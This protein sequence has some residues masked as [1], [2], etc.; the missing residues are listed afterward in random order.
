MANPAVEVQALGQ[1]IWQDF[2]RRG[3]IT[4]GELEELVD[5]EGLLGITSNPSIF[6]KA[7]AGS[8]DYDDDLRALASRGSAGPGEIYE[9]LALDDIRAAARVLEPAYRRTDGRDGFVSFE[10]SPH[11]AHDTEGTVRE[12]RRLAAAV[13]RPNVMIKV[14]GTPE[15]VPAIEQLTAEGVK[16]NVTLLFG[17]DAYEAAANAFVAGLERRA[18]TG[19]DLA[20]VASVASFF[21]SRIDTAVDERL[22]ALAERAGS[23]AA[24]A[25]LEALRGR[26]AIAD[27][28]VAWERY[29]E[30]VA[31][32]RWR[33]LAA[34]GARPQRLL[35]ASTSTKNPRYPKLMYV[36]ALIGED[37]VDT[38]PTG[39]FRE[40]QAHGRVRATLAE[41]LEHAQETLHALAAA[42][43][44]MDEVTRALLEDGVSKFERSFD[45][46]IA[47]IERKRERLLGARMDDQRL[48]LGPGAEAQQEAVDAWRDGGKVRRLWRGDAGLWTDRGEDRWLGWLHCV[49]GAA[50]HLEPYR[51]LAE[52]ARAAGLGHVLLLGMGGSSLFPWV[53]AR[54]VGGR[55]GAP[56]LSVLDSTLPG[57]IRAAERRCE[58]GRTL[59]VVSSK[60]GS[61]VEPLTLERHFRERLRSEGIARPGE[62]FVA[63]T[64]PGSPLETHAARHRY[65][66]VLAGD[67]AIGG[68]Y[69]ALSAFGLVPAALLGVAEALLDRAEIMVQA[70]ASCVPPD[71]NP[72]VSLGL[73]LGTLAARGV[74]KVTLA[75]SPSLA[76]FGAWVE[77]LL[78]EST[79]KLGRG[80]VP[81]VGE[82]L[83]RPEAYGKDR[84]FVHLRDRSSPP[85]D[86]EGRIATLERAGHPVVRIAVESPVELAQ[87]VFRWEMATA[88]AGA[89]LHLDPFD[90]PDVESSK[91][92]TR[93]LLAALERGHTWP[94]EP[95]VA[96]GDGLAV[97]ADA[98]TAADLARLSPRTPEAL[99]RAH[100]AHLRAGRYLA[101]LAW[102]EDSDDNDRALQAVRVAVRDALRVATTVGYGPRYLHSTGQLHKGGPGSGVFLQ[103][104]ADAGDEIPVPGERWGFG[105]L[106]AAQARGDAE[107][108]VRRGRPLLR[109]HLGADVRR[110]LDALVAVVR[111]A[112]S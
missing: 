88:V 26:A 34:R 9:R 23:E 52:D 107:E 20:G 28:K 65:R 94:E 79:G 3:V 19:R 92:A 85:G 45:A 102:L 17:L 38:L 24:R 91:D 51:R 8:S 72:G 18:A 93:R 37:T 14:P 2:I 111:R 10:V 71:A 89:V 87:E 62:R 101:L 74:D 29:R 70:C 81:V 33:A 76:P 54:T 46:L 103:I 5:R 82:P 63:I 6:E 78:A 53:L 73:A 43:I 35:W 108:L 49:P 40:F 66:R 27:A 112:V 7:I 106:A 21:L 25:R 41:G 77:Q 100:L 48:S 95:P 104:T 97:H 61:T 67:P 59:Y 83:G 4:S 57:R 60:S 55:Q 69:S 86:D 1:S 16:V 98:R 22:T 36:E 44:S 80:L 11:L 58:P 109:I 42:G 56:E 75:T 32:P 47:A 105:A 39:T 96:V 68:R 99:L 15:G 13:A 12:A 110:G 30:L 84:V 64:D 90:Q 50:D 31:S